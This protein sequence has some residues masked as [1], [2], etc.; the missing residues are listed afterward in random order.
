MVLLSSCSTVLLISGSRVGGRHSMILQVY[1]Q[2]FRA[3]VVLQYTRE[4]LE[5]RC[6][7]NKYLPSPS[8]ADRVQ[9]ACS[10][11]ASTLSPLQDGGRGFP[12]FRVLSRM[13]SYLLVA[14]GEQLVLTVGQV[15]QNAQAV[16]GHGPCVEKRRCEGGGAALPPTWCVLRMPVAKAALLTNHHVDVL[17]L[18]TMEK[19]SPQTDPFKVHKDSS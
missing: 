4:H 17:R 9:C 8:A 14:N 18:Q 19:P 13:G 1:T 10:T 16:N 3:S 6:T 5:R 12:F 15:A 7:Q 2:R 11:L